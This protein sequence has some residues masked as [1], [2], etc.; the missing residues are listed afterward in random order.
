VITLC[1]SQK[2]RKRLGL[3]DKMP[4]PRPS[5]SV[6]GDWY[7]SL[8]HFGK[9]QVVMATSERSLLSVVFPARELRKTLEENLR[10]GLQEVLL[11]LGI[12][13]ALIHREL[14]DMETMAYSSTTNRRVIGSTNEL[15]MHLGLELERTGDPLALAL[16][17]AHVPMF[18]LQGRGADTHPFPDIVTRELFGV[19]GRR[20]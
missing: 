16:Y 2:V 20:Q 1:C 8:H 5:T 15:S 9:F 10:T 18:A 11:A 6:L 12:D 19:S 13:P 7:V 14:K 17:L 3:P 4:S